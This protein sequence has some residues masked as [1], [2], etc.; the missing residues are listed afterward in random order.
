MAKTTKGTLTIKAGPRTD[1]PLPKPESA[2]YFQLSAIGGEV[3][4]LVGAI[5]L[6]ALHAATQEVHKVEGE[7]D[8]ELAA[9][10]THRF[11]LSSFAF[12]QL[13]KAINEIAEKREA[14]PKGAK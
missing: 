8:L 10:I 12:N 2:N 7:Q 4:L 13:H 6:R 1:E 9:D 11:L 14:F 5:D 3:Q